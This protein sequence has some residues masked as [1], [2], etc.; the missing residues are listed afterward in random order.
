MENLNAFSL[1]WKL[2]RVEWTLASGWKTQL[3]FN[4]SRGRW[5]GGS[6]NSFKKLKSV[7]HRC[8]LNRARM[9]HVVTTLNTYLMFEVLEHEWQLLQEKI[10]NTGNGSGS[11]SGTHTCNSIEDVINAHDNYIERILQRA[12]LTEHDSSLNMQLQLM[13]SSILRFC[14]LE[15]T[16]MADAMSAL[17]RKKSRA[18]AIASGETGWTTSTTGIGS[19]S[20]ASPGGINAS[21][22]GIGIT[23][24]SPLGASMSMGSNITDLP[25]GDEDINSYD[26]V[27]VYV[28]QRLDEA[29]KDYSLQFDNLMAMLTKESDK[30]DDDH[31]GVHGDITRFLALRLDFNEYHAIEKSKGKTGVVTGTPPPQNQNQNQPDLRAEAMAGRNKL[32]FVGEAR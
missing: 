16:L 30:Y 28:V 10:T 23:A 1:L 9:L 25:P 15:D 31:G 19:G 22:G 13:L 29:V 11:G 26:G 17:A 6:N 21:P 5:S 3:L 14:S 7:I 27:P 18:Q 8:S 2:K 32:S 24:A 20:T 12:L 4:H